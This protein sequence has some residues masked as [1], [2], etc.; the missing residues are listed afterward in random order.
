[1]NKKI[2]FRLLEYLLA[3]ALLVAYFY[4]SDERKTTTDEYV[5]LYENYKDSY[6]LNKYLIKKNDN[7]DLTPDKQWA[8]LYKKVKYY[9]SF[10]YK[11]NRFIYKHRYFF[12]GLQTFMGF[13]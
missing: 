3:F 6:K 7:L 13:I 12:E 1:M 5:H 2:V 8:E 11:P 9:D 4:L 10:M